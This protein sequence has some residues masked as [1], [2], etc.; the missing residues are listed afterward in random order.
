MSKGPQSFSD[1]TVQVLACRGAVTVPIGKTLILPPA[2]VYNIRVVCQARLL[3]VA[4]KMQPAKHL[5]ASDSTILAVADYL[6]I[7]CDVLFLCQ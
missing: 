5:Q 3:C 6:T 4:N 1:A 2:L 7:Q